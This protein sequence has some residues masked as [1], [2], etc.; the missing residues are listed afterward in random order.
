[1]NSS[2][3]NDSR[4]KKILTRSP[5]SGAEEFAIHDYED[6]GGVSIDEYTNLETVAVIA[7][8]IV[9][10][11]EL[12]AVFFHIQMSIL[13]RHNNYWDECYHGEYDS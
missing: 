4:G 6:F 12:G 13:M 3:R 5:I 1:M 10:H 11:D 8:F 9:E 7:E 2:F